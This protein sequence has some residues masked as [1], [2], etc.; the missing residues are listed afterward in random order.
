VTS[1]PIVY[2]GIGLAH[3]AVRVVSSLGQRSAIVSEEAQVPE[4]WVELATY[5][6][7]LPDE[8]RLLVCV[9][10]PSGFPHEARDGILR[11]AK[12]AGWDGAL[13]VNSVHAAGR[14]L[15]GD[16]PPARESMALVV[17]DGAVTSVGIL[18]SDP[19][20]LTDHD[21]VHPIAGREAREVAVSLR[22]MLKQRN[23][24]TARAALQQVVVLGDS[25]EIERIGRRQYERELEGVGAHHVVFDTDPFLVA[26]GAALI[27]QDTNGQTWRRIRRRWKS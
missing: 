23:K 5:G 6:L 7:P 22:C 17:V 8:H 26:Q 25:S 14:A 2:L 21:P 10:V 24:L 1:I 19:L 11:A 20:R 4:N 12:Q 27:A 9:A 15:I 13:I 3:G 16:K 18:R